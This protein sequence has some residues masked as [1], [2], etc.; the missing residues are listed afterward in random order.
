MVEKYQAKIMNEP[1]R[2]LQ[3][4]STLSF[5]GV[6]SVVMNYYRNI[7]RKNVQFDFV[8]Q[9]EEEGAYEKEVLALG[10]K[11]YR[12][13]PMHLNRKRFEQALINILKSNP[14][15][16]IIHAHQNFL[17]IIPLRAAKKAKI[18]VRI[19]HGHSSYRTDSLLTEIKRAVFRLFISVYATDLFACSKTA[20]VWLYG[21]KAVSNS[22]CKIIYNAIDTGKYYFDNNVR[23]RIRQE[24]KIE[25]KLALIHIGMFTRA[26][27]HEYLLKI[28]KQVYSLKQKSCLLLAGDGD[29]KAELQSLAQ[30]YGIS[31]NVL[32]LGKKDNVYEYLMA[33]DGFVFPSR[34]EGLPL[35]VIEAQISGLKCFV[36]DV[37]TSEVD[38]FGEVNFMSIAKPA[39]KWAEVIV[40]TDLSRYKRNREAVSNTRYDI[41]NEAEKLKQFYENRSLG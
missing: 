9:A 35:A 7:D 6:Q 30:D 41:I 36:S 8:V 15:Y 26:K 40:S 5:G 25:D 3:I 18:P 38:L 1:I 16:R 4:L 21:E 39:E 11:I 13:V 2:V 17:N 33:A 23:S 24:L 32:F 14:G 10:G 34:Y 19:S 27:N 31:D 28:F 12:T 22:K 29:K 20:A 37:V